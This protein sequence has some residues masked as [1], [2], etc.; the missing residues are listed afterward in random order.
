MR[1]VGDNLISLVEDN[2]INIRQRKLRESSWGN[3][4]RNMLPCSTNVRNQETESRLLM[5]RNGR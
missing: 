1:L 3:G 2:R 5:A 4:H